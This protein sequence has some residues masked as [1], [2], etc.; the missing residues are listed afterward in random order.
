MIETSGEGGSAWLTPP[1][2]GINSSLKERE[3]NRYTYMHTHNSHTCSHTYAVVLRDTHIYTYKHAYTHIIIY[4]MNMT[5]YTNVYTYMHA[6]ICTYNQCKNTYIHTF[7]HKCLHT[8]MT[9]TERQIDPLY[10]N[11]VRMV[12]S[13]SSWIGT[14]TDRKVSRRRCGCSLPVL[15]IIKQQGQVIGKRSSPLRI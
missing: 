13:M 4:T 9:Q 15:R 1:L 8:C 14:L 2:G 10:T 11:A 12:R 6:C 7:T 5:L 3:R